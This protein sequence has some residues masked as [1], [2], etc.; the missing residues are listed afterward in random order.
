VSQPEQLRRAADLIEQTTALVGPQIARPLVAWLR[1]ESQ[2]CADHIAALQA[3][4]PDPVV[5]FGDEQRP[6]WTP[7]EIAANVAHHWRHELAVADAILE[8]AAA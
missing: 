2:Q 6:L 5:D 7:D 1:D 8:G 4:R 3:Y